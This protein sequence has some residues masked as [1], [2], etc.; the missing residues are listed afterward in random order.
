MAILTLFESFFARLRAIWN[1]LMAK[2]WK[3]IEDLKP[4]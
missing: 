4:F 3:P 1:N 2:I